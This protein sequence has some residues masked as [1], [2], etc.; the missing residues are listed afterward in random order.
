MKQ[1]TVIG[2]GVMGHGIAQLVAQANVPVVLTDVYESSLEK[3]TELITAN[4]AM[5]VEQ[6]AISESEKERTLMTL[7]TSTDVIQSASNSDLVIEAISEKLDL[8]HELYEKL[9]EAILKETIIA[10]N[11]STFSLEALTKNVAHPE[12]FIVTHFFNPAQFVPLVEVVKGNKTTEDVAKRVMNF[13]E[14]V[15][16]RPILLQKDVPGFIANRLQA[17]LVREAFHLLEEGVADARSIDLAVTEGPGLR[18]GFSGP[19][20][21]ADFG[22]LDI[23]KSVVENLA[24]E[25]SAKQ[26]VPSFIDAAIENGNLG[27]KTSKGIYSYS[28]EVIQSRLVER[29]EYLLKM[30]KVRQ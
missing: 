27:T 29:D 1:V 22:G 15:G 20:E 8:K 13:M 7:S 18:W 28:D 10:S 6:Q 26:Q 21:T 30:S 16:K 23:W 14:Q 24:P 5:Q 19:L 25:L 11:T 4:L 3:A 9:E 17:A 12:R 2:S